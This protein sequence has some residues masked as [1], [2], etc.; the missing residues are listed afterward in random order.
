LRIH[1]PP[2]HSAAKKRNFAMTIESI[3]VKTLAGLSAI[4]MITAP[5]PVAAANWGEKMEMCAEAAEAEGIVDL[6]EFEP[7]FD[8][9]SSRRVSLIFNSPRADEEIVVECRIA[10]GQVVSVDLAS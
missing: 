8:G 5:L 4:A 3:S 9:A 6:A 10:R 2:P 7:E 1:L